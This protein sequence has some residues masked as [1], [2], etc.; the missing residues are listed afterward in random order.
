MASVD[1]TEA[2]GDALA[3]RIGHL[4]NLVIMGLSAY[5]IFDMVARDPN[6]Q[7]Q[8]SRAKSAICHFGIVERFSREANIRRAQ[9]R[10]IWEAM[11]IV[12]GAP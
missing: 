8:L 3:A 1:Y 7:M 11:T 6:V 12:E 2:E 9:G 4:I 5:L 10:V